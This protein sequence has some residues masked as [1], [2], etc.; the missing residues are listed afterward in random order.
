MRV[1]VNIADLTRIEPIIAQML[2]G[3]V[4]AHRE[5]IRGVEKGMVDD[6]AVVLECES[7]RALA[8]VQVIR[9]ADRNHGRYLTRAYSEGPKGGWHKLAVA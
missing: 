4:T 8:I 7:S 9:T 5:V 2:L 1:A 3:D 6:G